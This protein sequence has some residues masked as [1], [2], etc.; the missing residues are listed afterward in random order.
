MAVATGT[1]IRCRPSILDYFYTQLQRTFNRV[2]YI[3]RTKDTVIKCI[4]II[5]ILII[6]FNTVILG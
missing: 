1:F 3:E 5:I 4:I 6:E 2:F